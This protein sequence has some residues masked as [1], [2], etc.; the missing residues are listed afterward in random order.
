[1]FEGKA[2]CGECVGRGQV[3]HTHLFRFGTDDPCSTCGG[4]GF[5]MAMH[6]TQQDADDSAA[7]CEAY[8]AKITKH[9]DVV[10]AFASSVL[11]RGV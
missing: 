3:Y 6:P 1:M 10:L 9:P 5:V 2:L 8:I 11:G 4:K 7:A